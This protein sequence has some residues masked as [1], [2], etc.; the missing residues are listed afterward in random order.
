[1]EKKKSLACSPSLCV[2]IGWSI[3]LYTKR[4]WWVRFLNRAHTWVLGLVPGWGTCKR[5]LI[6]IFLSHQSPSL[7]SLSLKIKKHILMLHG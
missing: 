2:S 7:L 6:D 1:M 5:Q 3:V 4:W